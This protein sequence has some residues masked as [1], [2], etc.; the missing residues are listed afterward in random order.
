[1]KLKDLLNE[2]ARRDPASIKKEYADLKK[3][4]ISYLRGEWK[5]MNKVGNPNSLDKEGLISDILR[6][7]HGN[8]YVDKA[9]NINEDR[10][11][12]PITALGNQIYIQLD[13]MEQK[14]SGKEKNNYMKAR[15]KFWSHLHYHVNKKYIL[16][17]TAS[18]EK[19]TQLCSH[20]LSLGNLKKY[21]LYNNSI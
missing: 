14:L 15:S 3:Q 10:F 12:H 5:R 6:G 19:Y 8:K 18:V 9:F 13:K 2:G 21:E 11:G 7:A 17:E 4:S 20:I 1:M 16:T